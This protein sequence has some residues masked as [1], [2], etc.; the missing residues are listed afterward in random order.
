MPREYSPTKA[1]KGHQF[2]ILGPD[3]HSPALSTSVGLITV[4]PKHLIPDLKMEIFDLGWSGPVIV[5]PRCRG[6]VSSPYSPDIHTASN[7]EYEYEKEKQNV[8]STII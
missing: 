8:A 1:E 3:Q 4:V 7:H 6:S 2:F 5:N